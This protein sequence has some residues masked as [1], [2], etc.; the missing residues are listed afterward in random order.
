[1]KKSQ[2]KF[3]SG[4][5][6]ILFVFIAVLIF[7]VSFTG[8]GQS[9]SPIVVTCNKDNYDTN[10]VMAFQVQGDAGKEFGFYIYGPDGE[11]V[12]PL[13]D[14]VWTLN[15]YGMHNFY[16][17]G[18]GENGLYKAVAVFG[19]ESFE[20]VF[21]VVSAAESESN[22]E[23]KQELLP[24]EKN[25]EEETMN[26]EK[27]ET[28]IQASKRPPGK[29]M[30]YKKILSYQP[31]AIKEIPE[32][33]INVNVYTVGKP[34][35]GTL[36]DKTGPSETVIEYYA[37][38]GPVRG[39]DSFGN[40][41]QESAENERYKLAS[42]GTV[43]NLVEA[44]ETPGKV[45]LTYEI[46]NEGGK[47]F[48]YIA[49]TSSQKPIVNAFRF[50][51][52]SRTVY[53]SNETI[54][55]GD[56]R[57]SHPYATRKDYIP[58]DENLQES[59]YTVICY[60]YE[61]SVP[62]TER[63]YIEIKSIAILTDFINEWNA[64]SN[65]I[66]DPIKEEL[67]A[68][69]AN[70]DIN[71]LEPDI[72]PTFDETVYIYRLEHN[73]SESTY[74]EYETPN[75]K[76][77]FL[78]L[79]PAGG[80]WWNSS[81]LYTMNLTVDSSLVD[82]ELT[83]FP[84]MVNLTS[85]RFNFSRAQSNG[86]DIRFV[87]N[88]YNDLPH[89]IEYWN[90]TSQQAIIWTRLS[91]VSNTTD[92]TFWMYY[93]NDAVSDGQN[94]TGVWDSEFLLV[95]HLDETSGTYHYDSSQYGN[96]GTVSSVTMDSAGKIDGGDQILGGSGRYVR[97]DFNTSNVVTVSAW[98][99]LPDNTDDDMIWVIDRVGVNDLD[100]WFT[101]G[102]TSPRLF[103]NTWDSD[104]NPICSQPSG[105]G[106][107]HLYT[108]V[109]DNGNTNL[110]IDGQLAGSPGYRDPTGVGFYISW[111][112]TYGW[113]GYVDE[114]RVSNT[115]RSLAWINASFYAQNDSLIIY[116]KEE[117][118]SDVWW[119][120]SWDFR[121][122][123]IVNSTN[124]TRDDDPIE[125]FI[126]FTQELESLGAAGKTFD[127]NSIRVFE[128]DTA[129]NRYLHEVP[130]QFDNSSSYNATTNAY[131]EVIW[132]MNGTTQNNTIRKYYIY[133]DTTD[134]PKSEPSYYTD[135]SYT[136]NSG[137]A[138]IQNEH[139]EA[140]L[141]D[142][143]VISD[144]E[145]YNGSGTDVIENDWYWN[146]FRTVDD[147]AIQ[148]FTADWVRRY[149]G[150]VRCTIS[151]ENITVTDT[152]YANTT[153]YVYSKVPEI[154]SLKS[155][156][157]SANE[158]M[159]IVDDLN[160]GGGNTFN[161]TA[162]AN[163]SVTG[164]TMMDSSGDNERTGIDR[165]AAGLYT[166]G[167]WS[168]RVIGA[169]IDA[170][171]VVRKYAHNSTG[172]D[173]QMH[174]NWYDGGE[175][176]AGWES[177]YNGGADFQNGQTY[178]IANCYYLANSTDS[179]YQYAFG[180]YNKTM[181]PVNINLNKT[182]GLANPMIS[183]SNIQANDT[184]PQAGDAVL[185]NATI[186]N[187]GYNNASNI[188]VRFFDG[189]ENGIQ[190][191]SDNLIEFL[192]PGENGTVEVVWDT[193]LKGGS[194]TITVVID[195]EDFILSNPSDNI[196]NITIN[197]ESSL[198]LTVLNSE[199]FFDNDVP[200]AGEAVNITATIR[201][202]GTSTTA[203]PDVRVKFFDGDPGD[204]PSSPLSNQI[205]TDKLI[206]S[207]PPGNSSNV[208]V[209]W[210]TTGEDGYYDI[211]VWIDPFDVFLEDN[212]TNNKAYRE[213]AVNP[214]ELYL[215][216]NDIIFNVTSPIEGE[217]LLI[218]AT[219]HNSGGNPVYNVLVSFYQA[220]DGQN[221]TLIDTT[222]LSE[223]GNAS[224][225]NAS[226]YWDTTGNSG[227]YTILVSADSNDNIPEQNEDN[228]NATKPLFITPNVWVW[229]NSSWHYR[230]PV[231][232]NTG[233]YS[234]TDEPIEKFINF[235]YELYS[236]NVTDA[237]DNNSI[238]VIEYNTT[239][240]KAIHEMPSQFDNVSSYNSSINAYGEVIWILNGTTPSNTDRYFFI[241][242]DIINNSKTAPSYITDLSGSFNAG[243]TLIH[244]DHLNVTIDNS[245]VID[246]IRS[247]DGNS[248]DVVE[249]WYWNYFRV[250]NPWT[251]QDYATGNW[252]YR[253]C[254][255]V[256][257]KVIVDGI[258][259]NADFSNL[260]TAY[261][262]YSQS[263][264]VRSFKNWTMVNSQGLQIGDDLNVGGLT[265]FTCTGSNPSWI[266]TDYMDTVS[267]GERTDRSGSYAYESGWWAYTITSS[268]YWDAYAVVRKYV[269]DDL[270]NNITMH[271]NWWDDGEHAAGWEQGAEYGGTD[272]TAGRSY[273]AANWYYVTTNTN[274]T[275]YQYAVDYYDRTLNL[276]Q[277]NVSG[278]EEV[279]EFNA[280]ITS[281]VGDQ[282]RGTLINLEASATNEGTVDALDV[283][284][285]WTLPSGWSVDTG[286]AEKPLGKL[287]AGDTE[288]NNISAN[289][290]GAALGEQILYFNASSA[291]GIAGGDYI[292]FNLSANTYLFD[293][294]SDKEEPKVG[295]TIVFQVKLAYDNGTQIPGQNVTF[296]DKTDGVLMGSNITGSPAY[297][298]YLIPLSASVGTHEINAS[299]TGNDSV[300]IESSYIIYEIDVKD[301]PHINSVSASPQTIGYGYTV[302]ITANVT[303]QTGVD[304]V[305]INI[306]YPAG[307]YYEYDM[308]N[309]SQDIYEYNFTDSYTWGSFSYTIWS[310]N[311]DGEN[312]T[313]SVNYFYVKPNQTM[314]IQTDKTG[315][316]PNEMVDLKPAG[317]WWRASW[318][319]RIPI[320]ITE[321]SGSSLTDYQIYYTFDSSALIE[322][323]K[324]NSSCKDIRFA[325]TSGT[326]LPYYLEESNC[327]TNETNV[328]IKVPQIT[329][330]GN[331]TIYL[332]F[333]NMEA[334][335]E[336][337][338]T[339][340][341]TYD[342]LQ[343]LYYEINSRPSNDNLNISAYVN[344][345]NVTIS[346]QSAL[347]DIQEV[348]T[349]SSISQGAII[350]STGP[351]SG[352]I[353]DDQTDTF[354]P[355]AFAGSKFGFPRTRNG[356][357]YL[358]VWFIRT[359]FGD[360]N[361]T[362]YNYSETGILQ[363]SDSFFV[364][365]GLTTTLTFNIDDEGTGLLESN[366][367]ILAGYRQGGND[368]VIL[369]P[370]TTELYGVSAP[371]Y[372]TV[373]EDDTDL[374][375]YRSGSSTSVST[376]L[377][378]GQQY[379]LGSSGTQGTGN[380][381]HL[382]SDKP[383][384]A[385]SFGDGDGGEAIVFWHPKELNTEYIIPTDT[386]YISISCPRTTE[387]SLYYPN[388]TLNSTEICT[389]TDSGPEY[390]RKA[391]FGC[392]TTSCGAVYPA[393]MRALSN[394]TFYVFYEYTDQDETNVLGHIQARK[395]SY[396]EPNLSSGN[397]ELI[398]SIFDNFG[399]V[400]S[401]GYFLMKVQKYSGGSW[402]TASSGIILE[403]RNPPPTQRN[404]TAFTSL[405]LSTLWGGWNTSICDPG[406]YRAYVEVVDSANNIL[407]DAWGNDLVSTYNF[408]L[409]S[410]NPEIT[411][412]TH[413]NG[414]EYG[415]DEYEVGD[416]IEWINITITNYNATALKANMTLNVI[417]SSDEQA[418]W[419]PSSSQ[420][421]GDILPEN[422]CMKR[423]DNSSNGYQIPLDATPGTYT[424][425][426]NVSLEW[427]NGDGFVSL[428]SY[429][430]K[431][432]NLS[433]YL[434][435]ELSPS[436]INLGENST[437]NLTIFNPW[438]K[439]ATDINITINC[440]ENINLTCRCDM[441]GQSGENCTISNIERTLL[442]TWLETSWPYRRPINITENTGEELSDYQIYYVFDT[443]PYI[444]SGVMNSS[445]KDIMFSDYTGANLPYFL[446]PGTCNTTNTSIWIKVSNIAA[447]ENTTIYLYYGNMNTESASNEIS[448]FSYDTLQALYYELSDEA[449]GSNVYIS[450]YQDGTSVSVEGTT[451]TV[452]RQESVLFGSVS[453]G[454][455]ISS[456]GPVSG[457]M[458]ITETG[459]I[460]PIAFA[461]KQFAFPYVRTGNN[462]D[463]W[464]VRTL[465]GDANITLY[466]YTA[467]GAFVNSTSF[468]IP[469][470]TTTT[471][472]FNINDTGMGILESNV[473]IIVEYRAG[474][475]SDSEVLYPAT[476]E[477]YGV[478]S[479]GYVGAL[480]DGTTVYAYSSTGNSPAT[481]NLDRGESSAL[482]S[483]GGQGAG[484]SFHLVSNKPIV[485]ISQADGDGNEATV[486]WHPR[487]FNSEYIIPSPSE[488]IAV[489]C[490]RTTNITLYYSNGTYY[491]SQLCQSTNSSS[492]YARKALF[493]CSGSAC[494]TAGM[495]VSS[496]DTFFAYHEYTDQDETNMLSFKQARKSVSSEPTLSTLGNEETNMYNESVSFLL[497][498]N[499]STEFGDY[500]VNVTVT[501]KNLGNETKTYEYR[502]NQIL[503]IRVEGVQ[504]TDFNYP[505]NVTR[506]NTINLTTYVNNTR[507]SGDATNVWVNYTTLPANWSITA[508]YQNLMVG[509]LSPGEINWSNITVDININATQ[510][511]QQ[512]AIESSS[513]EGYFDRIRPEITVFAGTDV[514]LYSNVTDIVIGNQVKLLAHLTLDTGAD[515][516]SKNISFYDNSTYLG[517]AI[518]NS[519]GW[520][521]L[522]YT[523]PV[524]SEVRNHTF[525]A[526]YSI[527][528]TSYTWQ[529]YDEKNISVHD[530]PLITNI[531][532]LPNVQGFGQ[533][534]TITA[535]VTDEETVDFVRSY[536]TYPN[537]S[538]LLLTLSNATMDIYNNTFSNTWQAGIHSYYI[539]ANDSLGYYNTSDTFNFR[540]SSNGSLIIRG[541]KSSYGPNENIA[542]NGT[543]L[544]W[545]NDSWIYRKAVIIQETG[546]SN[547]YEYQIKLNLTSGNFNFSKTNQ[548][549]DDIR[550]IWYNS[551]SSQY[552]LVPYW[553][554]KWNY[555]MPSALIWIQ[556]PKIT[557]SQNTTIYMYTTPSLEVSAASN[558]TS[559]FSFD[560]GR[561][562]YYIVNY[563]DS[564]VQVNLT[565]YENSTNITIG[566]YT[567]L[568]NEYDTETINPSYV[569]QGAEINVTGPLSGRA[570]GTSNDAIHPISWAGKNFTMACTRS[571][572]EWSFYSPFGNANV[573]IYEGVSGTAKT[574]FT[575]TKGTAYTSSTDISDG[576]G[577]VIESDYPIL[578]THGSSQAQD[579]APLYPAS[580][581]LWGV[582]S[583]NSYFSVLEDGTS[584]TV[585]FSDGTYDSY[586]NLMRGTYSTIGNGGGD[587]TGDGVHIV[588]SK[589][590]SAISQGDGDGGE[591]TSFLPE[592]EL[593]TEYVLPTGAEY[594]AVVCVRDNTNVTVY[595]S[596]GSFNSSMMCN[597]TSYPY[598]NKLVFG[599][600]SGDTPAPVCYSQGV[601]F[602]A[603]DSIYIYYEFADGTNDGE[604]TNILNEKQGRQYFYPEP[605]QRISYEE[606]NMDYAH[607]QDV[608]S[609]NM[610]GYL[611]VKIQQ[612]SGGGWVDFATIINDISDSTTRT[613]NTSIPLNITKLWNDIG[614]WNTDRYQNGSYRIYAS[615]LDPSG[616]VLYSDDRGYM[617]YIH[618]F[619]ITPPPAI[620][621]ITNITVYDVTDK[622][623]PQTNTSELT[624]YGTN[625]TFNMY[626]GSQYRVE[627]L[628]ESS[629]SS[630][631][632]WNIA[633]S[634]ATHSG[635]HSN[636]TVNA[637]KGYGNWWNSSWTYRF[638]V[639]IN[640]TSQNRTDLPIEYVV[641][642][643]QKLADF[644]I[645][646][647]TFDNNSIR[648]IEYNTTT[649]AVLHEIHSQFDNSSTYNA[650]INAIGELIWIMNGTTLSGDARKYY[651]YF[652]T[653]DNPKSEPS[654]TT[655]LSYTFN[656]G[657][658]LI[659]SDH[660]NVTID[661]SGVID[662]IRSLD[663]NSSDVVEDWYWNYFR[664]ENP[665]TLQSNVNGN[666]AYRYCGPVRCKIVVD[667]ITLTGDFSDLNTTYHVYS[668]SREVR[669]FKNW[670]M[671]NSQGLQIGDDLN[672]G[673]LSNFTCTG[674]NPSWIEVDYMDASGSSERTDRNGAY[675]YDSGWWA[676]T[677]TSSSYWDAYAVV[678]KY[679]TDDLGNNF[680]MHTNWYDS[681]EHSAGWEQGTSNGG[682]DFTAGRSYSA[683][684]WYHVT[685][686]TNKTSYQ[687]AVDYYNNVLNE[688]SITNG[689]V[690]QVPSP[691]DVWYSNITS[692][693]VGGNFTSGI[694]S[695]NTSLGGT[696][697]IGGQS[698]FYYILNITNN[699]QGVYPVTLLV[700]DSNFIK[701]DYST[702]NIIFSE[703]NPPV[704]YNN[705]YGRTLSKINRGQSTT[706][707]ARWNETIKSAFIEYN[708]TTPALN[709]YSITLPSPNLQNWTNYTIST[710]NIWIL[711]QHSGK[712][713][714]T[715]L[716]D[717][718]NN[719]LSYLTF[720][721]WGVAKLSSSALSPSAINV[722][723]NSTMSCRVI[724]TTD[725][726]AVAN[727]N[728]SFYRNGTYLGSNNTNSTGWS[729]LN[730]NNT[731]PGVF[732]IKCNIT[733]NSTGFYDL[734]STNS[735]TIQL[736]VRENE[737][738]NYTQVAQ[739]VSLIHKG[740]YIQY[741]AYW[742]DNYNLKQAVLES[743]ET[744][745]LTNSSLSSPK[746][747]TGTGNWSNFTAQIPV[748]MNPGT[749]AWRIWGNDYF[750]NINVTGLSNTEVWGW[751][752][753]S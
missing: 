377:Q 566:A 449:S 670:T 693:Y 552:E 529:S 273:S 733:S 21:T 459:T 726:N 483:T 615:F 617:T 639:T 422:S 160:V 175:H 346:T 34:G 240:G 230:I 279:P 633:G 646:E 722:T 548:T 676:Y 421:C 118:S 9:A 715:D 72:L 643:T 82:A 205:G 364:A 107:W 206:S 491:S 5:L 125:K 302:T 367:S 399:S 303:D 140:T 320:N 192:G 109:I 117:A 713:Y 335:S 642:F 509:D 423:W 348:V 32:G 59:N 621:Y 76:T 299:F 499:S 723:E 178:T 400:N 7:T 664:V 26:G 647:K 199:I 366:V 149:C 275:S 556:V 558:K 532:A 86:E 689:S 371:G 602:V 115:S 73:P 564:G 631:G 590:I 382:L 189:D 700:D 517:S 274:T 440:P 426:W 460:A 253:Y 202:T 200:S 560:A 75:E 80:S 278:A 186:I 224:S 341:F 451:E 645:T 623:N 467:A 592:D 624:G 144:I 640:A 376:N 60:A 291:D 411:N 81:W 355:M 133:F 313:S 266:E 550:F 442:D 152:S 124:F 674:S 395:T 507:D 441:S 61:D 128:Y 430:F 170:F 383:I 419:G 678:R 66:F 563:R 434:E 391:Y 210:D 575:V 260:N 412:L 204:N 184:N 284:L 93:G 10:E 692:T 172:G 543:P 48:S 360:A 234:R 167:W 565:A 458:A 740:E 744:G 453:Q 231:T 372:V 443:T 711:G 276:S 256:R 111:T 638:P 333:N 329:A 650:T 542:V 49:L 356:T 70:Y 250:E 748:T 596:D 221:Y 138:V 132:I 287:S 729:I 511:P 393:G 285:N 648:V 36:A 524:G 106:N 12:F 96:D 305:R 368:A 44:K 716:N 482:G 102:Y 35:K 696:V 108:M 45:R 89:E 245:G 263:R 100:L 704:L 95:Q 33:A 490:P 478:S 352:K 229:W 357:A 625:T 718:Q 157:M 495:M 706:F 282:I 512:L 267:D 655:E 619:T 270:G 446:E 392:G 432:H 232:I 448:T 219:I 131:G 187:D 62:Y 599:N 51:E 147:W 424:F 312:I 183:S 489:A 336:S 629:A 265:N 546:G 724:D 741:S 374:Y 684:N 677:I 573:K 211:Y 727:Y 255:P 165:S 136:F 569:S 195:P 57:E 389:S 464:Q 719:T 104:G 462:N 169:S 40:P 113:N 465:F 43:I 244:S 660:L 470:S 237:L 545:W 402:A 174:T 417:D 8:I 203:S 31:D 753:A 476:T 50:A 578:V 24:V 330:S 166:S 233:S 163:P 314:S 682:T 699:T 288:W 708:S 588:S 294:Q 632:S 709:N 514:N 683:A 29:Y 92:T 375:I 620:I 466:N 280:T 743:N 427:E 659:H 687:Y 296:Y 179:D 394:D 663:G 606:E 604:E 594:V 559:V 717:N 191:G 637:S 521:Q 236:L 307:S 259:L 207:L 425:T 673:T 142:S 461:G 667:G 99:Q 732:Q 510:G 656:A 513:D 501:Y 555:S 239:T 612:N 653:T 628:L 584:V 65:I 438:S 536:I 574:S 358:D 137:N 97:H 544:D 725:N 418:S 17:E 79:D 415:I 327:N 362:I 58:Y 83:D 18:F 450:A 685:T 196:A 420:Y 41:I 182:E 745:I 749:L 404:F 735:A 349:F 373:L 127:N 445:C 22:I 286:T 194:H 431:V 406:T 487:E 105:V 526:T 498:T 304:T 308:I 295:E 19:E 468:I 84:V 214:P 338:V 39:S 630:T 54:Y 522:I 608:G 500:D 321:N 627:F 156:T 77:K 413:E 318:T 519:T 537:T 139:F 701:N 91:N 310:N 712:I 249:N 227:S 110:Y 384:V 134:S 198:D 505:V 316:G 410:P 739:N 452:D 593:D 626:T 53:H 538:S 598:P 281:S 589:R 403:D 525:N 681:S 201:N 721:V 154:R 325:D 641:N 264:E 679:V 248:S 25:V 541:D 74:I 331:T 272:F 334:E 520:S 101:D 42:Y 636:W 616:N 217:D 474:G 457:K 351:I 16:L 122:L 644:G 365:E 173:F 597:T 11:K 2:V 257:C 67:E 503:E 408:T 480:E 14:P 429:T 405:D 98:A 496:N 293:F 454:T 213:I 311:T 587:G 572:D 123:V 736:T 292:T 502:N 87:D 28:E 20:K 707:Y 672:V 151:S 618:N 261:H 595:N 90:A 212:E 481:I 568:I 228:N 254:G 654:Y 63:E 361:I 385:A 344:G 728:V 153:Y 697:G 570:L 396:P 354:A 222:T 567:T 635:L 488:Y 605:V 319:Y 486:F 271:T 6:S 528:S 130:S 69:G 506:N 177:G 690:S 540:V 549:G 493:T 737:K 533:N 738:P 610:S 661:N 686:N 381:F 88:Y 158:G 246:D 126:N 283:W 289:N 162:G 223:I 387:I 37:P 143:G 508:G 730:F 472:T 734:D 397:E 343:E 551:T 168:Y 657:N 112:T 55:E 146:A 492:E 473:S 586:S 297:L 751:M 251:N 694:V 416:T 469:D 339:A 23:D 463:V 27:T 359:P 518:T 484:S 658:T 433:N 515:S 455:S 326:E 652:D 180:Y 47:D 401:T 527:N 409:L 688:V 668:Q 353:L 428:N 378:R 78:L 208:S 591:I 703:T 742:E 342:E 746:T 497:I 579:V 164:T 347:I 714:A 337:N 262:V 30:H 494:Y 225:E 601:R 56:V 531:S 611:L 176:S 64:E 691:S 702:F 241:Y 324:M 436:R 665:W 268:S 539:W 671:V 129:T 215:S 363:N 705:I 576:N 390:P 340:V 698:K 3:G 323:G 479:S 439:N 731:S 582:S 562:I 301:A 369:Y 181:S 1:M 309:T 4:Q 141:D 456:T 94:M 388:G 680:T 554:E 557:A 561:G 607:L 145:N 252:A 103:L 298:E 614:G 666:W 155:W 71:M 317:D 185:I 547:L 435:S 190:I 159:Q 218:N 193:T 290:Y 188:K 710:T 120:I 407:K 720:E 577:V 380:A 534:V 306:T 258:T 135:L 220:A 600:I 350:N 238:R 675:A 315:Y 752:G 370:A 300:F 171:A 242:F 477:L 649:D 114:V 571:T 444:A 437:Y 695:W 580:N 581:D 622:E 662:D 613:I 150:P 328:W 15:S 553:I 116:G 46:M 209:L 485:G 609:T 332:Y 243:N 750:D 269:R 119:N 475:G 585:Y 530:K 85:G 583:G 651:I 345:T 523:I 68:A 197:V 322:S 634:N 52:R 247:L 504:L 161:C 277:I 216:S 386:Q 471:I 398:G 747:M 13:G 235:T 516:V 38:S 414:Y 379:S 121:I 226:V 535:N 603:N 447:S 669:S 148:S